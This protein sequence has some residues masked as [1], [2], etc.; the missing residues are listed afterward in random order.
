MASLRQGRC[1]AL[2]LPENFLLVFRGLQRLTHTQ[3][4]SAL[5]F[6]QDQNRTDTASG[7]SVNLHQHDCKPE[8]VRGQGEATLELS[9]LWSIDRKPDGSSHHQTPIHSEEVR[10]PQQARASSRQGC[11]DH[12]PRAKLRAKTAQERGGGWGTLS[13]SHLKI[14]C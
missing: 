10:S 5:G 8:C 2:P 4:C 3:P 1:Q 14:P 13:G 12:N 11:G 6:V 7:G 9:R